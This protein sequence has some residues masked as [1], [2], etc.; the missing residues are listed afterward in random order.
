MNFCVLRI[1]AATTGGFDYG[2]MFMK[3]KANKTLDQFLEAW[4]DLELAHEAL[5]RPLPGTA[6]DAKSFHDSLHAI[7]HYIWKLSNLQESL[8]E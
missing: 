3:V 1:S 4:G 7:A 2:D 5:L 6:I 8:S